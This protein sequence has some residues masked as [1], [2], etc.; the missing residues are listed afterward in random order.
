MIAEIKRIVVPEKAPLRP[1]GSILL[2]PT[3]VNGRKCDLQISC[4]KLPIV[5]YTG[6]CA[7][8]LACSVSTVLSF[9]NSTGIIVVFWTPEFM[10]ACCVL[11][12][13]STVCISPYI[14]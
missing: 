3:T 8:S 11:H 1:L 2:T 14:C 13:Q 5:K 6:Y 10:K 7:M 9:A 12:H 4:L